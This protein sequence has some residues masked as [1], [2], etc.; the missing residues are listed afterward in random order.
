MATRVGLPF[1]L[2]TSENPIESG[3]FALPYPLQH[4]FAN[5]VKCS[6]MPHF[7]Q[8]LATAGQGNGLLV[9]T[10]RLP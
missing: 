10:R 7:W 1:F 5:S 8:P 2:K 3:M 4:S 9:R 6:R